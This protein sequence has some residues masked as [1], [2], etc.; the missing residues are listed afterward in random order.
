MSRSDDLEAYVRETSRLLGI[1]VEPEWLP[2]VALHLQRLLDAA[3]VLDEGGA[4]PA[5]LAPRFEP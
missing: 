2:G 3:R 1:P 5:E 4:L